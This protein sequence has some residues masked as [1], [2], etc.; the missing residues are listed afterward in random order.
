MD[1][2][3]QQ[4]TPDYIQNH[5]DELFPPVSSKPPAPPKPLP[6]PKPG[7]KRKQHFMHSRKDEI[8]RRIQ[9]T[10]FVKQLDKKMSEVKAADLDQILFDTFVDIT[11]TELRKF[12]QAWKDKHAQATVN[13]CLEACRRKRFPKTS[14]KPR[15][16]AKLSEAD[17]RCVEIK[18]AHN[19]YLQNLQHLRPGDTECCVCFDRF[20]MMD[21]IMCPDTDEHAMCR[22][23]FHNYVTTTCHNVQTD[24]IPCVACRTPYLLVDAKL[25][26][27]EYTVQELERQAYDLNLK[28]ALGG[29]VVASLY[30]ECGTVAVIMDTDLGDGTI[31]CTCGLCYCTKCGNEVHG[32]LTC[33]APSETLRWMDKHAK[34]CPNCGDA[35]QKNGGCNHFTHA[36]RSGGC[37]YEFCWLCLS[38]WRKP[39]KGHSPGNAVCV[40]YRKNKS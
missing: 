39:P 17:T 5:I 21:T 24:Q 15:K 34:R 28:V 1:E 7:K 4:F 9:T 30:C 31:R 8:H 12:R 19:Q 29:G 23:C 3:L 25:H 18:T 27:S 11:Q 6:P 16:R 14:R 40:S 26:L 35:V 13:E 38:P 10:N 20:N 2:F 33:P 32:G 36:K 22:Q 37:G